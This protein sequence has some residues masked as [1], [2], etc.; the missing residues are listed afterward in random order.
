MKTMEFA[1][2][3]SRKSAKL[4]SSKNVPPVYGGI[5]RDAELYYFVEEG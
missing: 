2:H 5:G 4:K 1:L 3:I